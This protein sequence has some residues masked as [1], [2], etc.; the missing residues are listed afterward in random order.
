MK[1]AIVNP[2]ESSQYRVV[3]HFILGLESGLKKI[4]IEVARFDINKIDKNTLDT[5]EQGAPDLILTFFVTGKNSINL[6]EGIKTQVF[7]FSIDSPEY[8]ID[9]IKN[10]DYFVSLRDT[11][12]YE[13]AKQ[14]GLKKVLL[15]PHAADND[16]STPIEK[17]RPYDI[18]FF[19]TAL[20]KD[21]GE[22]LLVDYPIPIQEAVLRAVD[23]NLSNPYATHY[24]SLIESLKMDARISRE[25]LQ[26]IDLSKLLQ[27]VEIKIRSKDKINLLSAF[28]EHTVHIFGSD[29]LNSDWKETLKGNFIFHPEIPFDEVLKVMSQSKIVLNSVPTIRFGG[30]ERLFYAYQMGALPFTTFTPF[31]D[32]EF[33]P[34][35]NILV[36]Y[37]PDYNDLDKMADSVLKDES[38][39]KAMVESGR[40]VV[41]NKHTWDI[42]AQELINQLNHFEPFSSR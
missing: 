1:I 34:G 13:V 7:Y 41:K 16:F 33:R 42:R 6:F 32:K 24:D 20:S 2:L 8:F 27:M 38:K 29:R 36:Y 10:L 15:L 26:K 5:I 39:R 9:S 28:K 17:E 23:L 37:P 40:A 35:E 11:F 3:N 30:H 21:I 31:A 14:M 19:G 18:V 22:S 4:G 25:M 12:S